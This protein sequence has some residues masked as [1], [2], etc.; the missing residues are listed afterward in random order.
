M[1]E[2]NAQLA[3][4]LNTRIGTLDAPKH[5]LINAQDHVELAGLFDIIIS[6]LQ[7]HWVNDL[8]GVLVQAKQHL[9]NKGLFIATMF[10][11]QTLHELRHCM[12]LAESELRGGAAARVSPVVDVK[13]AGRLLQRT[14][15][16]L[17]VASSHTITVRYK[18]A[19]SLMQELKQMGEQNALNERTNGL[20]TTTFIEHVNALYHQH[21][22]SDDK[23][24]VTFEILTLTAWKN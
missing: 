5:D 18:N 14:G 24:N 21:Y 6:S 13:D 12:T 8:P 11:G 20:M 16:H 19:L 2:P 7:L 4:M 9:H 3:T 22:S 1:L 17:P 10:G 15:Y 23:I